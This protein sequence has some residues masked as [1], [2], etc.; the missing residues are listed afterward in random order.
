MPHLKTILLETPIYVT[1]TSTPGW[2]PDRLLQAAVLRL[3]VRHVAPA[4]S[5]TSAATP[6]ELKSSDFLQVQQAMSRS[7]LG[8]FLERTKGVF[9]TSNRPVCG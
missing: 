6:N 3:R 4:D 5:G 7:V 1:Y 2:P 8:M 9:L